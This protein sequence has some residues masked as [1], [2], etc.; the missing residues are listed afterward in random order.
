[1]AP[2]RVQSVAAPLPA[3]HC[4]VDVQGIGTLDL[5]ADYL[6]QVI[7]CENNGA[8]FE[9]LKAQAIAARSVA[10]YNMETEGSICDSQGCQV[11]T[12]N[13]TASDIHRQAVEATS[14]LYMMY[15]GT[16]T[17]GFYVA[18]DNTL[19]PPACIG[20][21]A[22]AATEKWV[23]YNEG[24]SGGA[25]VQTDLG[26]VI[27]EGDPSYGQNRGCM[28]QW[29]A[30]CLENDA[31]YEVMDI[32]RFY[33]G[34]DIEVVQAQGPCVKEVDGGDTGDGQGTTTTDDGGEGSSSAASGS[35]S[36]DS[37]DG[38][39]PTSGPVTGDDSAG[40]GG[41]SGA[42]D[43]TGF[44]PDGSALP[45]GYGE[46]RH[47]PACT[48]TQSSPRDRFAALPFLG[49]FLLRRRRA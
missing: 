9:A 17:Y 24:K 40:P 37:G 27:P 47:A 45:R 34:D 11:F 3:A 28:S 6:P 44:Y 31:S 33:Y 46:Q 5:E 25:V 14:G 30:R 39:G 35:G 42:G 10:Y 41:S 18:G 32:L 15:S 48:C 21:D 36:G 1:M 16:L 29:G 4:S 22:D 26:L 23:T 20:N 38:S 43:E 19:T 13:G 7:F 12:C 2:P 49:L 8:N